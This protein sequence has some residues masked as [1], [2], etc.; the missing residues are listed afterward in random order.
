MP[1]YRR[2]SS[3]K[4]GWGSSNGRWGYPSS[5]LGERSLL[6]KVDAQGSDLTEG[7]VGL[8]CMYIEGICV[9]MG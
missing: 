9:N 2:L 5:C 4:T 8:V 6:T 7:K 1:W 3:P